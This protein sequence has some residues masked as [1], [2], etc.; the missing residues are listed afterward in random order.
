MTTALA[1]PQLATVT[2]IAPG[3]PMGKRATD[4]APD[5]LLGMPGRRKAA[6]LML[7]LDRETS[8]KVMAQLRDTELEELS[9]ELTRAGDVSPD[10]SR[11]VL[12]EFGLMMESG[13]AVVQ[14]G[15][16]QAREMLVA[17]VGEQRASAIMDRLSATMVEQPFKFL[18]DTDAR[19]VLNF[20]TDEHP[21]T[22]ALVLAHLPAPLASRVLAGLGADLQA[23]VA[24]RIATMDRTS[25]DVIRQ[26][27][28]SLERRMVTQLGAPSA[29]QSSVG[30]LQPLVD[31]INRA[32][33]GTEKL[34][35]EGLEA[36]DPELAEEI[37]SR[38]F[39]FED[40]L[41]LEDRAVQLVLRQVE[42]STLAVALKGMPIPVHTKVMANM[43]ERAAETL[44]E[45]I[46]LLGPV[47]VASVEEAQADVVRVIRQLEESG[48]IVVRRGGEDEYVA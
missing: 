26:I 33:P 46:E 44:A 42:A 12:D 41:T 45:E 39:M 5:P 35:M 29:D 16:D 17:A 25:P 13:R 37:R 22:T 32:D 27:E 8:A 40:L 7:Q 10:I 34:I 20:I 23:D 4:T 11:A 6:I 48:Q 47:R 14:G 28:A 9:A 19:Q 36:R 43:S 38:M 30:G 3:V 24:H 31:I 15:A 18:H 21:Q 1:D 2:P